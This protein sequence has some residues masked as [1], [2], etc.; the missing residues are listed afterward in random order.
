[1]IGAGVFEDRHVTWAMP[2]VAVYVWS[3][4]ALAIGATMALLY[5]NQNGQ[6]AKAESLIYLVPPVSAVMAYFGF[7]EPIGL[8]LIAGFAITALGVA[9]VQRRRPGQS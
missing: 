7:G 3:V 4:F 8:A 9:L 6:A 2:L 5:L 1:M